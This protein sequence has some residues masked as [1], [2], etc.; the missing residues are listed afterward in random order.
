MRIRIKHETVYR[1]ETPMRSAVQLLRLTPRSSLTQFVRSWRV[2]LDADARLEKNEDAF[3]NLTHLA[4]IE[5]PI[6]TLRIGVEGEVETIDSGGVLQG[7][8]ERQPAQLFLRDTALTRLDGPIRA[9]AREAMAAEGGDCL[10]GLHRMNRALHARMTFK[11]G[12]TGAATTAAEAFAGGIGVC[13]DYAH[14]LI[15]AARSVGVPARYVSGYLLRTDTAD[16]DAGH[17]W[18]EAHV[19]GLGWVAFD[20]AQG[21]CA[22]ERHVRVAVGSDSNEAAPIRGARSGGIGEALQVAISVTAGRNVLDDGQPV[23]ASQSQ[24]Q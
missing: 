24:Q 12:A 5:G 1:Y 6:D 13:Q 15:T 23:S 3:G 7:S 2:V 17:A 4:F 22:T 16:Q 9:F 8:V 20:P 10:A 18:V 14:V 11:V 21:I 19:A